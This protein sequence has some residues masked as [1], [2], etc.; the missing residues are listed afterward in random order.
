MRPTAPVPTAFAFATAALLLAVGCGP[1]PTGEDASPVDVSLPPE[2]TAIA[3]PEPIR[4]DAAG[5]EFTLT[6]LAHY[7][8]RGV[9]VSREKYRLGWN[10]ALAPC[11]VAMVWGELAADDGWRKLTWSQS[12]RWYYWRWRGTQ[13]FTNTMV[14]QNSSNTHVVPAS[15]NLARAARSLDPGEIAELD[16]DL[17]RIDGHRGQE[18][19]WWVSSLSRNDTRDGSC[20][21]LYLRR[22]RVDGKVYE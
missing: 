4:L 7:V 6:P 19:V 14:A 16:G 15:A 12:G 9:V 22:L 5:Y 21:I 20:E 1:R 11:D 17:V 18:K 8:L 10:A 13:P 2:Q 3:D